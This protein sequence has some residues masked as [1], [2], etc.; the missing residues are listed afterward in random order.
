MIF[1]KVKPIIKLI[2][3]VNFIILIIFPFKDNIHP[4]YLYN[5]KPILSYNE[6][7]KE[8]LI[9][10]RNYLDKCL[11]LTN[12]FEYKYIRKPKVSVIIPMYNCEK[13]IKSTLYSV[14]NQNLSKIE[15]ILINDFSKDN[16]SKIVKKSIKEDQRI[17]VIYNHKNM[18]TLYSRSIA[19]LIAKGKYIF[20]LD[21]DDLYFDEDLLDIIYKRAKK[22][23]IDVI[24]FL[25]IDAWNYNIDIKNMNYIYTYQYPDNLYIQQP[26]LSTW[27]IKFNDKFIVHNNM[28]W[29]KCIRT[30]VYQKSV[31]ILGINRYSKFISW[32]EDTSMNFV[33]FNIANNFKYVHKYGIFHFRGHSTASLRQTNDSKISGEIFFFDIIFDFSKNNSNDKNFIFEQAIYIKN[34]YNMNK[35]D[36]CTNSIYLMKVLNKFINC[37]LLNKKNMRKLKKLFMK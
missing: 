9:R 26:E 10:G 12:N 6:S 29:D 8:I 4:F 37:K 11:N 14:Q 7:K 17:K 3:F 22:E 32:S 20:S 35:F 1:C 31:N 33:I 34:R 2:F 15:I 30:Y 24:E 16:T 27:M 21:N 28:I 5:K 19:A 13:T 23:K 36:N 25:T 18:G